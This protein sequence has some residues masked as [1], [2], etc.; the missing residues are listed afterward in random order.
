M[1]LPVITALLTVCVLLWSCAVMPTAKQIQNADYGRPVTIVDCEHTIKTFMVDLVGVY[2]RVENAT[3]SCLPGWLPRYPLAKDVPI[4]YG[5][6]FHGII[7]PEKAY[8]AHRPLTEFN[9]IV[10]DDGDGPRVVRYCVVRAT[11]ESGLC[12]PR[13]VRGT[14][15]TVE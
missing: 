11:D 7:I 3:I 6:K 10:R 8:G 12:I 13:M 5:Y 2:D 15:V 4:T 1:K 14:I 9:G